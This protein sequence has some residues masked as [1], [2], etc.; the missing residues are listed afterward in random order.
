MPRVI[1]EKSIPYGDVSVVL[2]HDLDGRLFVGVGLG[3][4]SRFAFIHVDKVT[5]QEL[6]RREV[7]LFTVISE[8][9]L[10]LVFEATIDAARDVVS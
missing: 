1:V 7:D 5:A 3:H 2:A 4:G 8:R 6:E 9:G 10:G